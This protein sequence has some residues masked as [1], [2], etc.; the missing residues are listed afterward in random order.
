LIN[1][2]DLAGEERYRQGT[3]IVNE[4]DRVVLGRIDSIGYDQYAD[5]AT[6]FLKKT[7][8]SREGG[9]QPRT[10]KTNKFSFKAG[11]SFPLQIQNGAVKFKIFPF[12]D[13]G[14]LIPRGIFLVPALRDA[15]GIGNLRFPYGIID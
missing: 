12:G 13:R 15:A 11:E 5:M 10:V 7:V 14:V 6:V 9:E 3:M 8:E 4:G 2:N 1:W